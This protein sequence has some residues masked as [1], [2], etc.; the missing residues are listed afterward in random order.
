MANK[1]FWIPDLTQTITSF[2]V[3]RS[4][5][6]G[7]TFTTV[8]T[9]TFDV[10]GVNFDKPTKRFFYSDASGVPGAVYAVTAIG[11]SGSSAPVYAITP[12]DA[13]LTCTIIGYVRDVLGYAMPDAAIVVKAFGSTG[14]QWARNPNGLLA[15]NPNALGVVSRDIIVKPDDNGMWQVTLLRKAYAKIEIP[16]QEFVWAFEVPDKTGPINIRDIPQLRGQALQLFPEMLGDR[17]T[18]PES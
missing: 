1:V 9:I 6:K 16:S 4:L 5:D 13:P 14:E 12:A 2:Q 7:Q 18:L 10:N 11:P 17:V 8:A 15:Q 3:D